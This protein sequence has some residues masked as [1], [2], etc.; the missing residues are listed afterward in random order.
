MLSGALVL[1]SE[2]TGDISKLYKKTVKRLIILMIVFGIIYSAYN[3]FKCMTLVQCAKKWF[4]DS[5]YYHL[6]YMY[7]IIGLYLLSPF[8]Y[9]IKSRLKHLK[10]QF[11]FVIGAF[12]FSIIMRFALELPDIFKYFEYIGYFCCRRIHI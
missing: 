7:M 4:V 2:C 11:L 6:W 9:K 3:L 8:I 10:L 12:V 5:P 1:N